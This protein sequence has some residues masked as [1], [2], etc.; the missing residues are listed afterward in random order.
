MSEKIVIIGGV[1]AGATGAAKARRTSEDVDITL[2]EKGKYISFANCGLPYYTGGT[3]KKRSSVLLHTRLSF[4][5][6]FRADVRTKTEAT[7]IDAKN[8][9]VA[10]KTSKGIVEQPYDKLLLAVGAKTFIPPIE[11]VE[12]TPYFTMRTV[13][14]ADSVKDF[15]E[16]NKPKSAVIIGAGFIGIEVAEAMLHCDVK[17]YVVEALDEVMPNFPKVVSMNLREKMTAH[18]CEVIIKTFVKK[19]EKTDDGIKVSL[20]DGREVDTDMILMC[21]GV[22]PATELALS[23]GV[24]LG[25]RGGVLTND[26]METNVSD[27]YAAGDLVE[28][29]HLVTGKKVLLPL[30]GPANRE[31]RTAGANMAGG[32]MR[33][34]GVLGSAVVGFEGFV[35]AQTGLTYDQAI[36]EGYDADYVYT[37][38][39]NWASYYPGF[40]HIFMMTTFDKRDGRLLGI[41]ACGPEGTEKRV[42]EAAV[43]IFSGLTVYDL[44][45]L[46][47]CYAPPFASAKDN[48]NIAGFVASNQLRGTGYAIKPEELLDKVKKDEDIQIIDVRTVAEFETYKVEGAVNI[49]VNE[50]REHLEKIDKT[51]PVYVYCA[52]GFRGYLAVRNLRNMGYEAYNVTGGIEAYERLKRI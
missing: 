42:D 27:I 43:A 24:Q 30:A 15:V 37:E 25:E 20:S 18:G 51:R 50:L 22:K 7:E 3:I 8:K 32:D 52:V 9:I 49:Y 16:K 47:L 39:V 33:F 10:L 48:L 35:M 4:G 26:K 1:A 29:T 23:A 44:E 17:P 41:S 40:G 28:K 21:T 34:R 5:K 31:G 12:D 2:V 19:L 13:E 46:E 45:D 38:D 36:A 11:G 6:R 14:D